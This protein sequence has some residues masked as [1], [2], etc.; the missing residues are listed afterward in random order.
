[1]NKR[2]KIGVAVGL[3]VLLVGVAGFAIARARQRGPEVR[4]EA[5]SRRDLISTV[6]ASGIIEPTRKVDISADLSGRVIELAVGEGQMVAR[7]DLLLRIDPTSYQAAVRRAEAAV[8]QARAQE[9]QARANFLQAQNAANRAQQLAA[10]RLISVQEMEQSRTNAEVA[11]AQFQSAQFSVRQA[12]ASLLEARDMFE[13][14][15]IRAPMAG[16]VTRLNIEE[17]ETAIVGTMNNPGSLLLTVADLSAMAAAV[18]VDE[19][20]IP[21]LTHGDRAIVRIDAFP[22]ESFTGR[23]TRIS[24]SALQ[25]GGGAPNPQQGQTQAVDFEVIVTLDM[26]PAELRPDLSATAEIITATRQNVLAVPII[27]VTVRDPE[28]RRFQSTLEDDGPLAVPA[29]AGDA[30][31]DD[32]VEGVFIVSEGRAQFIPVRVGIAGDQYFEV[33][34]GLG[35]EETVIA[36]PYAVVRDLEAGD[37][38]RL[39]QPE[40]E[41]RP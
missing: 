6:T 36:G 26:P 24:S 40:E 18:Q 20:D 27:A 11:E 14:T 5:V 4:V 8:A 34:E 7:G 15:T 28:G 17:G 38:V 21:F 2:T 37:R 1:M 13:K 9:A 33:E 30:K 22:D 16:R 41:D 31:G 3:A 12:E 10:D 32:E 29:S 23:V 39:A 19:T 25:Q 35:E